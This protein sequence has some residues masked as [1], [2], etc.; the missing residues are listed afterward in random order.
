MEK[1]RKKSKLSKIYYIILISILLFV[2]S[3]VVTIKVIEN[4]ILVPN[5]Q[6]ETFEEAKEILEM[7]NLKVEK[8]EEKNSNIEKGIVIRQEPEYNTTIK[9]GDNVKV[10]VSVEP[11]IVQVP[12]VPGKTFEEAKEILEM[13][14][15]KVEKIEEKN[16]EI[17][18]GIV[19][20]Q[21]P[22]YNTPI[23]EGETVKVYVSTGL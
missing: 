3:M 9:V 7:L 10:Y 16:S 8:I 22:V 4:K 12:K 18:K 21:Y 5:V 23:E 19:I 6:G 13:L 2:V 15:L 14:N 17:K 1:S 20:K 11:Q